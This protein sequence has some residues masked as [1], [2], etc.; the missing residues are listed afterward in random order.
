MRRYIT[1]EDAVFA[2]C[3]VLDKFGGCKMGPLCP[4]AGC[5]EVRDIID[6]FPMIEIPEKHGK[7]IEAEKQIIELKA[8]IEEL[9]KIPSEDDFVKRLVKETKKLYKH[10]KEKTEVIRQILYKVGR[11]DAEAELDAWIED[12]QKPLVS[13]E[14]ADDVIAQGGR[15]IINNHE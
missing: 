4:D 3:K 8:A 11:E 13:I 10:E 12:R 1:R 15:K 6:T 5:C 9:K 7:L 14:K 2:A